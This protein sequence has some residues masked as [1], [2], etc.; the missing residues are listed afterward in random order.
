MADGRLLHELTAARRCGRLP[1]SS[2]SVSAAAENVRQEWEDGYRRLEAEARDPLRYARLLEQ[3]DVLVEELR[4]RLG[5]SF[6]LAELAHAYRDAEPWSREA[7]AAHAV[8]PDWPR[9]VAMV[10][11]AAFHLYARRASDYAP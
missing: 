3:V 4:R 9:T 8:A 11:D 7:L 1:L 10:E 2:R 5:E 6:T